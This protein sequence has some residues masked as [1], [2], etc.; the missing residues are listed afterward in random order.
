VAVVQQLHVY[1]AERQQSRALGLKCGE[2]LFTHEPS[3]DLYVK[4]QPVLG[5]FALGDTLEEQSRADAGGINAREPGTLL[6]RRLRAIEIAPGGEPFRWR[7]YDIAQHL[8][9]ETS[10]ALR[11][12]TVESYLELPGRCHWPSIESVT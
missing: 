12:R 10:E 2:A 11:F 7:R 8:T 5:S 4:V 1:R 6:L 9:P 3:A